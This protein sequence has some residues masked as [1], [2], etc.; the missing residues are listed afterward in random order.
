MLKR[1][2]AITVAAVALFCGSHAVAPNNTQAHEV[3]VYGDDTTMHYL[4]TETV[5][6]AGGSYYAWIKIAIK[7]KTFENA[8]YRFTPEA[9][10]SVTVSVWTVLPPVVEDV[11]ETVAEAM[12]KAERKKAGNK[13][14][15]TYPDPLTMANVQPGDPQGWVEIGEASYAQALEN[16]WSTVQF[17]AAHPE[18][19]KPMATARTGNSEAK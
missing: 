10:G 19:A 1:L 3:L 7:N 12:A 17:Y 5:R 15:V 14:A 11:D 13:P 18:L 6:K 9:D 16:Y 2:C 4:E 8:R